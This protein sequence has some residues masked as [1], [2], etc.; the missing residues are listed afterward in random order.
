LATATRI[1]LRDRASRFSASAVDAG[2]RYGLVR[3]DSHQDDGATGEVE[4]QCRDE[5]NPFHNIPPFT[6]M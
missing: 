5:K 1:G 4:H 3:M 6:A 2:A